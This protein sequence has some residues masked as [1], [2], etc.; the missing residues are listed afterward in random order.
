M[1][2]DGTFFLY[3]FN[4]DYSIY[5]LAYLER[6]RNKMKKNLVIGILTIFVIY[7]PV[8]ADCRTWTQIGSLNGCQI[9][10]L[11]INPSDTTILY[12]GT[13]G[14]G[15]FKSIDGG[16]NWFQT[17]NGLPEPP[18]DCSFP[19]CSHTYCLSIDPSRPDTLYVATVEDGIFKTEDGGINW[20]PVDV[21]LTSKKLHMAPLIAPLDPDILYAGTESGTDGC[22]IFKSVNAGA[23]WEC[24]SLSNGLPPGEV[25]NLSID[26]SDLSIIYAGKHF[27][28]GYHEGGVFKSSNGGL[29]WFDINNPELPPV[30]S[31]DS[32]SPYIKINPDDGQTLYVTNSGGVFKSSDGGLSWESSSDGLYTLSVF[33]PALNPSNPEIIYLGTWG[34]GIFWSPNG[35]GDW[36]AINA[37]LTDLFTIGVTLEPL[38]PSTIYTGTFKEGLVFKSV[39][40]EFSGD[41]DIDGSDLTDFLNFYVS[42]TNPDADLDENGTVNS[43]DLVLFAKN[44]GIVY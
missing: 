11:L 9:I 31:P 6:K 25:N 30:S 21:G 13:L 3:I 32:G 28:E 41:G 5:C 33:N 2:L 27:E 38:N 36:Q 18:S 16:H 19:D 10:D 40:G 15:I 29:T 12:A 42:N 35:A 23:S 43:K 34:E 1:Y 44:F 24:I 7:K 20:Y 26:P 17:N 14:C 37:G 4:N 8:V 39:S 22:T